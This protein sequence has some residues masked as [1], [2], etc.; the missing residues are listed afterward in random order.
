MPF[1]IVFFIFSLPLEWSGGGMYN[2]MVWG[3]KH[4]S[5]G[6]DLFF[7]RLWVLKSCGVESILYFS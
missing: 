1:I 3:V 5:A 4:L 7:K 6:D 2:R